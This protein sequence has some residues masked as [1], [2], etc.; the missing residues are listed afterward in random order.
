MILSLKLFYSTKNLK[1]LN[2]KIQF[3]CA[4]FIL[5]ICM[6]MFQIIIINEEIK[7]ERNIVNNKR[8]IPIFNIWK[9]Y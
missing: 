3:D 9:L 6:T 5:I 7:K 4:L 1:E 8:V 2:G